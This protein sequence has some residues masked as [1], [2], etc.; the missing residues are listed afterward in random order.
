[1]DWIRK[2]WTGFVKHGFVKHGF[3][4]YG[5]ENKYFVILFLE[6]ILL[7]RSGVYALG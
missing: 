6:D 5:F 7:G 2:I 4:K 1:M 3:V